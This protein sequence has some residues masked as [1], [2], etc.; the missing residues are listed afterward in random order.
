LAAGFLGGQAGASS[1]VGLNWNLLW[2]CMGQA[3]TAF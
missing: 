2:S 3:L 1:V